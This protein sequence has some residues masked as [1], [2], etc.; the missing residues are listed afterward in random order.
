MVILA[1]YILMLLRQWYIYD[2]WSP[3]TCIWSEATMSLL[4][5][6]QG[7]ST[8]LKDLGRWRPAD[9]LTLITAV[10]QVGE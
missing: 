1:L 9:D 2:T 3:S 5:L 4:N 6:L 8:P 10:L 7:H